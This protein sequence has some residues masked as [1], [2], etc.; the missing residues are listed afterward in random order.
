[1]HPPRA[2]PYEPLPAPCVSRQSWEASPL[3]LGSTDLSPTPPVLPAHPLSSQQPPHP[4]P[5]SAVRSCSSRSPSVL[6]HLFFCPSLSRLEGL[7]D[8]KTMSWWTSP[9]QAQHTRV[10]VSVSAPLDFPWRVGGSSEPAVG[11][12]GISDTL[13]RGPSHS[14]LRAVPGGTHASLLTE[15]RLRLREGP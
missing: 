10:A 2:S 12:D 14:V 13:L 3:F 15:G 11:A 7:G 4:S 8:G 1:M 9:A 5:P 6:S